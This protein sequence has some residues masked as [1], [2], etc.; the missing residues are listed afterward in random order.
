MLAGVRCISTW[1]SHRLETVT[2]CL[3][4]TLGHRQA[5]FLLTSVFPFLYFRTSVSALQCF[6]LAHC[7]E[8]KNC[9]GLSIALQTD[10]H[11]VQNARIWQAI[12]TDGPSSAVTRRRTDAKRQ[13]NYGPPASSSSREKRCEYFATYRASQ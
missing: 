8:A 5:A 3:Q 1:L 13:R 9:L 7:G 10:K 12:K 2:L 6:P 4:G 11:C